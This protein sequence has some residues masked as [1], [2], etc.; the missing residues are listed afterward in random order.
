[1]VRRKSVLF[2]A[3]FFP[4]LGGAGVQ[5]SL[6]FVK[7]LPSEGWD[8]TVVTVKALDYWMTDESLIAELGQQTRIVR[9]A[10]MTGLSILR[11]LA[12]KQAG[13]VSKPRSQG[14][15]FKLLRKMATCFFIPDS[16]VGWV[17]FA[18]KAGQE[19]LKEEKIDLIYTTSSPDSAHLV[20][21]ELAKKSGLPWVADFRDPWTHRLSFS[22]PTRWHRRR[23]HQLER[24]VFDEAS[25]I[26]V[27]AEATR[28]DYLSIYPHIDPE[29]I[30]VVTNG[31]D[32]AD[33][34]S[35][36]NVEPAAERFELLHAG[37]LNPERPARPFLEGLGRFLNQT[38]SARQRLR[39]RFIGASYE[40]DQRAVQE[41]ALGDCVEFLPGMSHQNVIAEMRR[42]HGLIL[43]ENDSER[44]GLIL[45]GKIFEYLRAE[46]PILG[47]L[48]PGAAW[49]LLTELGTGICCRTNDTEAIAAGIAKL[50]LDFDTGAGAISGAE[51]DQLGRFE[52]RDLTGQL[53]EIFNR[54]SD[55]DI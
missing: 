13:S 33:F 40:S 48:P 5:R 9:T 1:V 42:S 4:P 18:V 23:H 38:P 28:Q 11:R 21:R 35:S 19:L 31:F 43:M 24:S 2:I 36:L 30:S 29:K 17:P 14:N 46:R 37:Q 50:W 12:P 20:G 47:L 51:R 10:S 45:P 32:E 55:T 49:D 41:L 54:L 34:E 26:T 22:P 8:P 7:Y 16:Y 27:T 53:S 15:M 3:Y 44:G 6:K 39:V 25:Q 52:R